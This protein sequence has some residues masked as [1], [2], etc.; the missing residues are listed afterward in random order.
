MMFAQKKGNILIENISPKILNKEILSEEA[1][2]V[3][4][5][6]NKK[7]S[8]KILEKKFGR[9]QIKYFKFLN[10]KKEKNFISFKKGQKYV[11]YNYDL[12]D[13]KSVLN[14]DN[15]ITNT[16]Y[17]FNIID[18][19]NASEDDK[20][21]LLK[22]PNV[23]YIKFVKNFK[24]D[25][26]DKFQHIITSKNI[27]DDKILGR[28]KIFKNK[29]IYKYDLL[30]TYKKYFEFYAYYYKEKNGI[31]SDYFDRSMIIEYVIKDIAEDKF[32]KLNDEL[33]MDVLN[34]YLKYPNKKL[35]KILENKTFKYSEWIDI[36]KNV[37][38]Y[39]VKTIIEDINSKLKESKLEI[40]N[41]SEWGINFT[42]LPENNKTF[43]KLMN[44]IYPDI[45]TDEV[46]YCEL[47]KWK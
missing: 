20:E 33:V 5:W 46:Q 8:Q 16:T 7:I 42:D 17:Y 38:N 41:L 30:N 18:T 27:K 43:V 12:E 10:V 40:K 47:K 37:L 21:W 22:H 35:K 23:R 2:I 29:K 26:F 13:L 4:L 19:T 31:I 39:L 44:Y 3:I 45:F 25:I 34:E 6:N 11:L 14:I 28:K 24:I 1:I 32:Y 9:K 36:N 15:I